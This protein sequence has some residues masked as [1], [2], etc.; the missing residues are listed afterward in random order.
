MVTVVVELNTLNKTITEIE[1]A[2]SLLP[3]IPIELDDVSKSLQRLDPI[4][5]MLIPE[6]Q[7]R[8]LELLVERAVVS[9]DQV[10]VP[11][12]SDGIEQIVGELSPIGT[13][14]KKRKAK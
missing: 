3:T 6:E 4:W 11:F 1:T 2:H 13:A 5:E 12:R 8:V 10:N 7:R 9:K 14:I